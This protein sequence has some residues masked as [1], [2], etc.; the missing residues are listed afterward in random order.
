MQG[1]AE[2]GHGE[3]S[4]GTGTDASST[5]TSRT[6]SFPIIIQPAQAFRRLDH[7]LPSDVL[8]FLELPGIR[9]SQVWWV[10][11]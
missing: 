2:L 6:T 3:R 4:V 8:N 9:P 11:V 7:M 1:L 5:S 10:G